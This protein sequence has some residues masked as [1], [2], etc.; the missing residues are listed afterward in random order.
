[1]LIL[2]VA[3]LRIALSVDSPALIDPLR[4]RYAAFLADA[5]EVPALRLDVTAG[6]RGEAR[7]P[8]PS[9]D[10]AIRFLALDA[11][12]ERYAIEGTAAR[13]IMDLPRDEATVSLDPRV[14]P[15]QLEYLLR[16]LYA[17]LA[18]REGGLLV[19]AA[20]VCYDSRA[21]LFI[22][23]SGSG[24]TTV[25]SLSEG[26]RVLS[27]DLVAVRP[28]AGDWRA[29]STPFWN[30]ES[31]TPARPGEAAPLTAIYRLV[32]AREVSVE[33]LALAA[34]TAELVASCPIVNAD[35]LQLP[36]LIETCRRLAASVPVARL[37][38]RKD[39]GFWAAIGR[40]AEDAS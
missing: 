18:L 6:A 15:A 23:P 16:A 17:Y 22:G 9:P 33:P 8:A 36:H 4:G 31:V 29:Y 11:K 30:L 13:G 39:P 32:Q 27:D 37:F 25:S 40:P 10:P 7:D 5:P 3:G 1:M 34:A 2:S 28:L 21:W 38:F 12:G 20:G 19:H 14:A 35:P 26:A 24:K